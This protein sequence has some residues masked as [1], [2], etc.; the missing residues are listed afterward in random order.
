MDLILFDGVCNF[1]NSSIN[2]IIKKDK[3]NIFRF[4]P[5]QSNT[6]KNLLEQHQLKDK[7]ID[8]IIYIKN[9]KAYKKSTAVL[10]IVKKLGG[11]YFLFYTFIIIPP[12]IRDLFY[13]IIA[14][15]RYRWFG[16]REACMIPTAEVK[17]KF[18]DSV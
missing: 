13:D 6:G 11:F 9:G 10:Q 5:L 7:N 15:N 16:K 1:C 4:A 3:K 17:S 18:I 12:F 2:F 14:R 8:S